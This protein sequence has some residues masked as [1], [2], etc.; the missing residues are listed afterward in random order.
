MLYVKAINSKPPEEWNTK[1]D[2]SKVKRSI[3]QSHHTY[4]S[5]IV[6]TSLRDSPRSFGSYVRAIRNEETGIPTVRRSSGIP[7]TSN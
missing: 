3:R 4:I 7:V 5:E 2:R 1:D 6:A